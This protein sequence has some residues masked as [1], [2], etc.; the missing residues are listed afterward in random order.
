MPDTNNMSMFTTPNQFN[1][2]AVS[3]NQLGATEYTL[4]NILVDESSSVGAFKNELDDCLKVI[5]DACKKHPRSGNLLARVGTFS[6]RGIAEIHGFSA[7]AGIDTAK[8]NVM[9]LGS[10]PLYDAALD[11]IQT[12]GSFAKTLT[13]QDYFVN[14]IFFVIT[15]GEE[16]C[17][18]R[19]TVGKIK[20]ELASLRTSEALESVKSILIGVNVQG[21]TSAYLDDF[22]RDAGFDEYIAL[23][24]ASAGKL[25][26]LAAWVSQ[27]ISSTSQALGSGGPSQSV[28]FTI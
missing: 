11:A 14:G 24:D 16:N 1:Y 26:K 18:G 10:T 25:A 9:P 2:S 22:K 23:A 6:S 8:Y 7:I 17:S 19:A 20:S 3:I 28:S 21:S 4:I 15:D 12:T 5:I 13:D 27:S